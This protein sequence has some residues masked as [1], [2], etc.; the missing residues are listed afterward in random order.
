MN[1]PEILEGNKLIAEF[2]GKK[3]RGNWV[4]VGD[5]YN[6][7][8]AVSLLKYNTDW[9]DLM[10]VWCKIRSK[11]WETCGYNE[12]FKLFKDDFLYG[13]FNGAIK[14]SFDVVVEM[15]NYYTTKFKKYDTN[16]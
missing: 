2:M 4:L 1:N 6:G 5:K 12:D 10:H 11:F 16:I 9:N 8:Y 15:I 7:E 14:V 13:V 3:I